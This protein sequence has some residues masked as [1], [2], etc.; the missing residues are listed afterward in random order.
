MSVRMWRMYVEVTP[1]AKTLLV[2]T[3][4]NA[5]VVTLLME[6]RVE[7]NDSS[8]LCYCKYS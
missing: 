3:L 1:D 5:G 2:V 7:V 4:V 8:L 6:N